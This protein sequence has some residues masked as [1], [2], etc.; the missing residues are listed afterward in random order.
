[1]RVL[2]A[3][4]RREVDALRHKPFL[5]CEER[6]D[7]ARDGVAGTQGLLQS[8]DVIR[9]GLRARH[10]RLRPS[11]AALVEEHNVAPGLKRRSNGGGKTQQIS[12]EGRD[13]RSTAHEDD[14]VGRRVRVGGREN[15][16]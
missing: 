1:M 5:T 10:V 14:R 2:S 11:D 15:G 16:Y 3:P 6:S 8:L 4:V 9:P 7:G 12:V 13:A